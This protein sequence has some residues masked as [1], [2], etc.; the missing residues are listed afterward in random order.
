MIKWKIHFYVSSQKTL[1]MK[2]VGL[3]KMH[4]FSKNRVKIQKVAMELA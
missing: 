1:V 2:V 3:G 4:I